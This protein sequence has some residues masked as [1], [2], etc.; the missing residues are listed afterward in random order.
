MTD[1]LICARVIDRRRDRRALGS[2]VERCA[3][4]RHQVWVAPSG[5][6][7]LD[8]KQPTVLCIPC[9]TTAIAADPEPTFAPISDAQKAEI[10][11]ALSDDA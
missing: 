10:R 5:Q 9:G 2:V 11:R 7:L 4:C 8:D 6:A 3:E 1:T